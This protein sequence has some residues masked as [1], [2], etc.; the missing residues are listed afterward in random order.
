MIYFQVDEN[1][2]ITNTVECESPLIAKELGLVRGD[3]DQEIGSVYTPVEPEVEQEV[4]TEP[5]PT[6]LDRVEA[7]VT[8][9]AMMT[10]TLLEV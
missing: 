2:I 5:A 7:Q 6:Q 9:T 3:Y 10:D 4:I 1:N 8:Y